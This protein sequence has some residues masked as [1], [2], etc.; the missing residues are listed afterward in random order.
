MNIDGLI[1]KIQAIVD[2]HKL[3]Q[4]A[5][6]RCLW[7]DPEGTRK[8]GVNE[9]GCAD[10]ANILYTIGN[11]ER[12]PQ[13]R[14]EWV[15]TLQE[16]QDP[17]TGLF[18]EGT[19]HT[20]HTTA[21]CLAA[22][23]LFDALPLYPLTALEKYLEPQA[24]HEFLRNLNW[25]NSP[26]NNSHQGAGLFAAMVNT[27]T[28]DLAWQKDYFAWLREHADP[29]TGLGLSGR[30]GEAPLAHQLFGWFHYFFNHEFA[31]QPIPYPD[32][33]IDS[34]IDM[35]KNDALSPVFGREIGFM[36]IDWIFA[37][38]R[39]SR[40]TP[41]RFDEVRELLRDHAEKFIPWLDSLDP[42]THDGMNDLHML[43]GAVCAVAELQLAL[44]GEIE[45]TVPLKNVL[46]RRPF[47]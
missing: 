27:R 14:A 36:E 44:P 1:T 7:Q 25:D 30:R 21:H 19:H 20:I 41:H 9:Y 34:C 35:Y 31:H 46:D 13:K 43:F 4:G 15:R 28:A 12:D 42:H 3:S 45:S 38:N 22:L 33:I 29:V 26:W 47:V 17:Q 6:S 10:A 32:K 18:Y 16:M 11:F 8:M 24:L 5:Y 39:A 40:Q 2:S 37:M 23:E